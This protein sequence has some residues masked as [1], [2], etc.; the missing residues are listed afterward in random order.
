MGGGC[1]GQLQCVLSE[2]KDNIRQVLVGFSGAGL[3]QKTGRFPVRPDGLLSGLKPCSIGSGSPS[4]QTPVLPLFLC[5]LQ[6]TV[7][8]PDSLSDLY[9]RSLVRRHFI[10][11]KTTTPTH[12]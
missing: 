7:P 3:V 12:T 8:H 11:I 5:L 1:H 6:P 2:E 10:L 9:S 4:F